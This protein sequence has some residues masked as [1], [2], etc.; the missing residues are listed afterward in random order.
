MS[1]LKEILRRAGYLGRRSEFD[2]ELDA[3]IQ[4]HLE[5]RAEELEKE[6]VPAE[7]ARERAR[8]EFG[9]RARVSEDTRAAWQ[10]QW[11]EDLWRDLSYGARAFAKSPGFTAVAVLSLGIGVGANFVMFTF[12]DALLL[13]PPKMPRPNEVVA[14]VSTAKDSN[15][16]GVSFPDYLAVR[17]RSQ[18]I[19]DLA[20]F[21]A[22]S[23]GLA[24]AGAEPKVKDGK[25]VTGN[26]FSL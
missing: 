6:G 5:N 20:A 21:T 24:R 1:S 14:L 16:A 18:S 26:Y 2:Q 4:F 12:V 7:A 19:Q 15:S 3:E 11:L 23:A 10:F 8:R 25:L 22:V 9:P 17:D 13:R